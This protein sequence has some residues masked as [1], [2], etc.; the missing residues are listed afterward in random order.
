MKSKLLFALA[1]S[2]SL[3]TVQGC[4]SALAQ[5]SK[6]SDAAPSHLVI[7]KD[8]FAMVQENRPVE[9]KTGSDQIEVGNLSR[10]LDPNSVII[11]FP[12]SEARVVA[13][14]FDIGS[15]DQGSLVQKLAGQDVEVMLP[16]NDGTLG[17][18]IQG[19]IEPS[20]G[21]FLL[22]TADKTYVNPPG[23][24]IAPE[25]ANV[26]FRPSLRATVKSG[27]DARKMNLSYLTRGLSWS[28]DYVAKLADDNRM[29]LELWATV[30]NST[31]S[32][33]KDASIAF[34]AGSPNRSVRDQDQAPGG[35]PMPKAEAP[36]MARSTVAAPE[37]LGELYQYK[38][39]GT[40]T[41]DSDQL[42]R[43]QMMSP[44]EVQ[45]KKD[46]SLDLPYTDAWSSPPPAHTSAQLAVSFKNDK[47]SGLGMPL[48]AGSVRVYGPE[49]EGGAYVGAAGMADTTRGQSVFLTLSKVFDVYADS[50]MTALKTV[51]KHT[52]RK[53]YQIVFHN[54]KKTAVEVRAVQSFGSPIVA[55]QASDPCTKLATSLRQW[56][57]KVPAGG[58][59]TVTYTVDLKV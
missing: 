54:E 5:S 40:A 43:V 13:T 27:S 14:T 21:G 31:G 25:G 44:I 7:Y 55:L 32:R 47:A 52:V 3:P 50:K 38:A 8:D 26:T 57:V 34:V 19:T 4:Q 49:A 30:S 58:Q 9:L 41:I 2:A 42:N 17:H 56:K 36:M 23:T 37:A 22:H 29:H 6:E 15:N 28:A 39:P 51:N 20:P 10:E 12:G 11:D 48:P 1:V 35:A 45:I 24:L 33:F 59:K 16:S 53:T 18:T 46:Y